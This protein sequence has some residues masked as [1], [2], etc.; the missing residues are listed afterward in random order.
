M[1]HKS[2]LIKGLI[3]LVFLLISAVSYAQQDPQYTHYMY[4]TLSVN[5]AYAGQ[6]ETLSVVG[7]HRSQWVGI[8]GAPQTQSLGIHTPLRN[9]RIG[10]GLNVVNDALGPASETFVDANFSYTIPLNANDLKLSFGAKGGF[11]MLDTDWSKGRFQNQLDAN[12]QDN[13]N[14]ISPMI[15]AGLYMHTRKWYLGLA[16]PNF[17]ETKH[18]DDYEESVATERMHFY[19]IGGYVFNI[20]ETT[21]LKPAFLLKGVSGAPMI[22]DVSANF[23]FQKK[24]TLGLAWRWDDSVSALA[25][26]QITPGMFVGYSYDMT[27]TGLNNYNSGTH[28]FTLRFEVKR[29]GRILSPRFF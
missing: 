5:P 29:L 23:W 27:T 16:V 26:F 2:S 22:A 7:L 9:E 20:S 24:V 21:E 25:G 6:R 18:Y 19:L 28:E 1:I 3:V 10:L 17:I 4:N 12:F 13:I 8:D 14:L 15:G 11:H